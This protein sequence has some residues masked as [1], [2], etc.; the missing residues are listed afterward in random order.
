MELIFS[1]RL[2]NEMCM[3]KQRID[4]EKDRRKKSK[5]IKAYRKMSETLIR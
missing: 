4:T 1:E 5:M 3:I 2:K